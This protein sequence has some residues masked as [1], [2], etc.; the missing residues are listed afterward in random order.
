MSFIPSFVPS[1][2]EDVD[3]KAD[4]EYG[5]NDEPESEKV[6]PVGGSDHLGYQVLVMTELAN[7]RTGIQLSVTKTGKT[8]KTEKLPRTSNFLIAHTS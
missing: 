5:V 2:P 3:D 8:L 6:G 7:W 4:H 1:P